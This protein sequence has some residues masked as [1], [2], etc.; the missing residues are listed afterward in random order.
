[1]QQGKA[2]V[3]IDFPSAGDTFAPL[4][5]SVSPEDGEVDVPKAARVSR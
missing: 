5:T 4:V 2:D 1:M 3:S